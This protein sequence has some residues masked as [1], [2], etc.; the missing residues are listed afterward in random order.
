MNILSQTLQ[1]GRLVKQTIPPAVA[2]VM[3][4]LHLFYYSFFWIY[5]RH[6]NQRIPNQLIVTYDEDNSNNVADSEVASLL[7]Q[8]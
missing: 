8:K 6:L 7:E 5:R 4:D 3:G 2:V 1:S